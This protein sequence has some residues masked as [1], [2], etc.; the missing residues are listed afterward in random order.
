[1]LRKMGGVTIE[2]VAPLDD[3]NPVSN[4]LAKMKNV[5]VP[6]HICYEV[7]DIEETIGELK[8]R[9]YMLIQ[10]LAPAIAFDNRRV[11]FMLKREVG[12]IE[13]LEQ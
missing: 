1:M 6:Y 8:K 10:K 4:T 12:L 13:L 7:E 5:S 9:G 11:V 3:K 2:L